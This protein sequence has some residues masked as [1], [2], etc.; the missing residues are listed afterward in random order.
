MAVLKNYCK[1]EG[2]KIQGAGILWF[3]FMGSSLRVHFV[4]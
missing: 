1:Q 4:V 2:T 3:P